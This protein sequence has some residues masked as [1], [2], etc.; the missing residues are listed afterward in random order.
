MSDDA[1]AL[2]LAAGEGSRMQSE[3]PKVCHRCFGEPML[4]HVMRSL[5]RADVDRTHVVLGEGKEE[6]RPLVPPPV[7]SVEQTEP[8]GTADAVREGLNQ[9]AIPDDALLL[10][11]CGDI[12]GVRPGTYRDALASF[13]ADP[14][15]LLVLT[16][17]LEDPADY[18]R[19]LTDGEGRVRRIVE[20]A[21][22]TEEQRRVRRVNAGIL[23]GRAGT[24][25][26]GIPRLTPDN[27][28][29]EYYLTDLVEIVNEDG[30]SVGSFDVEDAWEVTGINTRRQLVEFE[31]AGY[32][33]RNRT[34]LEAGVTIRDP[35]RVKLGPWVECERDV[36][37]EGDVTVLG[38]SSLGAGSRLVG[39]SR[40]R[41]VR[42]GRECEVVQSELKESELGDHVRVGPFCH[43]RPGTRVDTGVRLGNFVE[44]KN[45]S[46]GEGTNIAHLS[47]VGDAEIGRNV[48][49]GAGTIT[50][51]YDG[52]DKHETHIG[53]DT[54]VGS[55]TAFVAPVT[56]GEGALIGAGST[57]TRDVPPYSLA[58]TRAEQELREEWVREVWEPMKSRSSS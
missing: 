8:L 28:A 6:V 1:H 45:A 49:V 16:T 43:V 39:S 58:L 53:D 14:D 7:N 3:V 40:L 15:D 21:D 34:L 24:F 18:G 47:Y 9:A 12:P 27:E 31:R 33:K 11:T 54:F 25:R 57:I 2:V 26:E 42:L 44:I 48:N 37:I 38:Q 35:D 29:G 51:N 10:V 52:Y 19:V 55:N 23:C 50:C 13:R 5:D 41:D 4:V 20:A 36:E 56:V 32:R 30:G 17:R 46:V 22:A